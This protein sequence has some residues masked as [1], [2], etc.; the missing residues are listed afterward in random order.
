MISA[1]QIKRS[2]GIARVKVIRSMHENSRICISVSWISF[3]HQTSLESN[4]GTTAPANITDTSG[5]PSRWLS[6]YSGRTATFLS[7]KDLPALFDTYEQIIASLNAEIKKIEQTIKAII[8]S[9]EDLR[10]TLELITGIKRRWL[11][12]W[13]VHDRVHPQLHTLRDL[14]KICMLCWHRSV[15]TSIRKQCRRKTKVSQ[16]ANKQLKTLLHMTALRAAYTDKGIRCF[17]IRKELRT[18]RANWKHST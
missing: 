2:I 6:G 10:K 13:N 12:H 9:E 5:P 15:R 7:S 14:A 3:H 17:T 16:L 1:P 4:P 18:V 11:Y 8:N